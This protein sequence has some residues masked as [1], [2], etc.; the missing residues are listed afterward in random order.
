ML[1]YQWKSS[2]NCV[3]GVY[4][5]TACGFDCIPSDMG[6]VFI[7]KQFKGTLNS[8]TLYLDV[9]LE[10]GGKSKPLIGYS[11]NSVLN[12]GTWESLIP[13]VVNW[14]EIGQ[15]HKMLFPEAMSKFQPEVK[16]K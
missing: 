2:M 8:L 4:V 16:Q 9:W 13:C 7:Q 10:E 3:V 14:K 1:H 6:A 5:V 11:S 12:F 15:N